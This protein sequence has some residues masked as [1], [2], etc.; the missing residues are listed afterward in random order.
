M[1]NQNPTA[2]RMALQGT[3]IT[4]VARVTTITQ[5]TR[6]RQ[7]LTTAWAD[8]IAPVDTAETTEH[9]EPKSEAEERQC[10]V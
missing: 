3:W 5:A 8:K 7:R 6:V 4:T 10:L 2:G 1:K 9:L